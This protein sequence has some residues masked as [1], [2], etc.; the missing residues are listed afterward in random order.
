MGHFSSIHLYK[1]NMVWESVCVVNT[2]IMLNTCTIAHNVKIYMYM[3]MSEMFDLD[4][5]S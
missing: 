4:P 5:A 3:Y 1:N 2:I